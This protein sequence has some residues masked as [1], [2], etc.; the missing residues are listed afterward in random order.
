MTTPRVLVVEDNP[1]N[2]K[3]LSDVLDHFGYH[4]VAATTGE[5]GARLAGEVEPDL[6]LMDLQLPGIDGTEALRRIRSTPKGE[7]V[8]VLSAPNWPSS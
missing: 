3:L 5:D 4:V 1:M 7:G 2:L 8:P 6:I